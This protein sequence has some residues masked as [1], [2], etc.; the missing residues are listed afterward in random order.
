MDSDKLLLLD[1]QSR[2]VQGVAGVELLGRSWRIRTEMCQK[3]SKS[4]GSL[5]SILLQKYRL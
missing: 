5:A 1:L 2:L 4:S 3:G